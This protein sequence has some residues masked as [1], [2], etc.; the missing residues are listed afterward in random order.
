MK[1]SCALLT[2]MCLVAGCGHCV[3]GIKQQSVT[4]RESALDDAR[5]AV[6]DIEDALLVYTQDEGMT[7]LERTEI[8]TVQA[9]AAI[10]DREKDPPRFFPE[11]EKL[12]A[13]WGAL[14]ALDEIL[15]KEKLT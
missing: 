4:A 15:Q 9:D 6:H 5:E 11:V 3:K 12:K 14:V 2:A 1:R 10:V 8:E 13:D 7:R